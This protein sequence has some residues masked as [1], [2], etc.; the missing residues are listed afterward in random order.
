MPSFYSVILTCIVYFLSFV[1]QL[2]IF[3]LFILIL[4]KNTWKYHLVEIY[5][6]SFH[7]YEQ[8]QPNIYMCKFYLPLLLVQLE[9]CITKY[10]NCRH[11]LNMHILQQTGA[12]PTWYDIQIYMYCNIWRQQWTLNMLVPETQQNKHN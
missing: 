9:A 6:I 12:F 4:Y 8:W 5:S 7:L 3:I 10:S 1:N 11:D 2:V